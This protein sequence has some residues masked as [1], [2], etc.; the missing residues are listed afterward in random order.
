MSLDNVLLDTGSG[1]TVFKVCKV[2]EIGITIEKDNTIEIIL[3][4]GG[5]IFVYKKSIYGI[6]LE[7]IKKVSLADVVENFGG[8]LI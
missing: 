8:I 7:F 3:G 1:G 4:I 6:I 2:N 5:V